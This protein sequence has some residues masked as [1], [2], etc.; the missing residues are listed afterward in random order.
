MKE[1][2]IMRKQKILLFLLLIIQFCLI[3]GYVYH[4]KHYW[5]ENILRVVHL[6][7]DRIKAELSPFGPG[8]ERELVEYFCSRHGLKPFWI[9]VDSFQ[10]ALAMI[11]SGQANLLIA[12]PGIPEHTWDYIVVG[13]QYMTSRLLIAHNQW[14]HP[15]RSIDDLCDTQVVVPGRHLFSSKIQG[16]EDFL[17]CSIDLN[18]VQN[19]GEDFFNLLSNREFRFG[20]VDELNFDLWHGFFPEVHKTYLFD[21]EYGYSWIWGKRYKDLDS[22]FTEFWDEIHDDPYLQALKDKYFGFFPSE[23]DSYQLRHFV[24]AIEDRLPRYMDTI[25]EAAGRYGIDPLLLTAL[26]YQESHFNPQ[27]QSRTGVRG[28]LQITLDT[29]DFLGIE[30]R[31]DPE[32]SIMGGAM[33]LDYLLQ[34]VEEKG[35]SSW[36]RWFLTLAAYNQG[37]GHLYDAMELAERKG[38]DSLSWFQLKQ[39]YPL[40]SYRRYFETLP[41]GYGRGFEAVNFVDNIRYYYYI[42]HSMISLSRP[43]AEH[44]S[45]FLDFVPHLWPD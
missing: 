14:R 9:R 33:Y 1:Q 5:S 39:V 3:T 35:A 23:K 4:Q 44:L 10:D 38:M 37:L 15:L 36:D 27:A 41:R 32:Q 21:T 6:D 16:L 30:N 42:L 18:L 45:G 19:A 43:E 12:E 22:L 13:P 25:M 20:L 28:L 11:Q 26:I 8:F 34:Q 24:R 2:K 17:G 7:S 31:L 29:A 40:L